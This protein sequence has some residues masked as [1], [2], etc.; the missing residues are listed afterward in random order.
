MIER[1][2]NQLSITIDDLFRRCHQVMWRDPNGAVL[3]LNHD[4]Q[5]H[6]DRFAL[7]RPSQ[8]RWVL[9]IR[10][11]AM[12][13]AGTYTCLI[14]THPATVRAVR[15]LVQRKSSV[16][17]LFYFIFFLVLFFFFPF[18]IFF[19]NNFFFFISFSLFSIFFLFLTFS[20]FPFICL[21]FLSFLLINFFGI[22]QFISFFPFLY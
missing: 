22:F 5:T 16:S 11:V 7:R 8:R 12:A 6:D 1:S 3:T 17:P 2:V 10:D 21:I 13:D 14:D 19:L 15:L 9:T 20:Y 4:V 18:L